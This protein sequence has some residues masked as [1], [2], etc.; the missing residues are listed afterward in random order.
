MC[1]YYVAFACYLCMRIFFSCVSRI[2]VLWFSIVVLFLYDVLY[3][4][5]N[6]ATTT[7]YWYTHTHTHTLISLFNLL[8]V[9][10]TVYR[11]VGLYL[12]ELLRNKYGNACT[13]RR[14]PHFDRPWITYGI[15]ALLNGKK[16]R[17]KEPYGNFWEGR[18]IYIT[19]W[20]LAI[21]REAHQGQRALTCSGFVFIQRRRR[22]TGRRER[23]KERKKEG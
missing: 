13:M 22:E 15:H 20:L 16:E 6:W 7:G 19:S 17:K 8:Y 14:G 18:V 23:K 2:C 21:V 12:S 3:F 4:S 10:T 5:S 11:I 9:Y 1:V